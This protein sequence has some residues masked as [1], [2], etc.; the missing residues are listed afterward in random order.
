MRALLPPL[1][2]LVMAQVDFIAKQIGGLVGV[3]FAV[4]DQF[5][6]VADARDG[7]AR[8]LHQERLLDILRLVG[9]RHKTLRR[10][11][12]RR[13]EVARVG[14]DHLHIAQNRL[15]AAE[16]P[17]LDHR[18][19]FRL[20]ERAD[21]LR[22]DA[23]YKDRQFLLNLPLH[24]IGKRFLDHLDF[25]PRF[26]QQVLGNVVFLAPRQSAHV[27]DAHAVAAAVLREREQVFPALSLEV[28]SRLSF[29][30]KLRDDDA[31]FLLDMGGI[32]VALALDGGI[33]L[34]LV[35]VGRAAIVV[36]VAERA[37]GLFTG[38]GHELPL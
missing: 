19:H 32:L 1:P 3:P 16:V 2:E 6:I 9:V 20:C 10:L 29:V 7:A 38:A 26:P 21:L 14:G 24:I 5:Q 35:V 13:N 28:G 34:V 27:R 15:P 22:E 33:V 25:D 8:L 12:F 31:A 17:A 18:F 11:L 4:C 36:R 30:L 37:S 23:V